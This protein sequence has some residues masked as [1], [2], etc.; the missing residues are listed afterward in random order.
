MFIGD[1]SYLFVADN[2]DYEGS[3]VMW[4]VP[5]D[6]ARRTTIE[7]RHRQLKCFYDLTDFHSRSFNA[8]MAQV[9][10]V[11]LSYT[12]RQWQLWK[13]RQEE[14]ANRHPTQICSRLKPGAPVRGH[15][16]GQC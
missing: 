8:V 3:V 12:L 1:G 10:L 4:Q 6:Y 9:V 5:R 2:P 13:S 15:L 14:L 11:L 16:P 7:E